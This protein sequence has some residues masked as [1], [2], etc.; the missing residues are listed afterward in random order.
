M[1]ELKTK[2]KTMKSVLQCVTE[3]SELTNYIVPEQLSDGRVFFKVITWNVAGLRGLEKKL[4]ND[5]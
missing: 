5:L 1:S 2:T 3:R 4:P